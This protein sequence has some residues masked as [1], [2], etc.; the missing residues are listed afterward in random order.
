[1]AHNASGVFQSRIAPVS[2]FQPCI[3]AYAVFA[4]KS[5]RNLS[6][7]HRPNG[8]ASRYVKYCYII[9]CH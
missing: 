8:E 3:I 1:M 5:Y 2:R 4:D 9:S 7:E 6:T